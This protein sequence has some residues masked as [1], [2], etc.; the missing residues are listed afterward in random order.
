[1][2]KNYDQDNNN[3]IDDNFDYIFDP[4]NYV[5]FKEEKEKE[6]VVVRNDNSDN[7]NN[8]VQSFSSTSD[9]EKEEM[10]SSNNINT[11]NKKIVK[12]N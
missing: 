6:K 2:L 10:K 5:E 7:E 4:G 3:E 1:M 11:V 12:I 9:L 8:L